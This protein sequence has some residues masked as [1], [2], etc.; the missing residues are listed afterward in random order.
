MVNYQD[1]NSKLWQASDGF[2]Q[3]GG[4]KDIPH[5]IRTT[6]VGQKWTV[7]CLSA[8]LRLREPRGRTLLPPQDCCWKRPPQCLQQGAS[9]H[10][11]QVC[12]TELGVAGEQQWHR[13]VHIIVHTWGT[14]W[15]VGWVPHLW[16]FYFLFY[17]S[18][19]FIYLY[20]IM[21]LIISVLLSYLFYYIHFIYLYIH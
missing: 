5:G 21:Y 18:I 2:T 3:W 11:W 4:G 15:E 9:M 6:K 7:S 8:A 12:V 17:S 19:W 14:S 13:G 20:S 16:H 10:H 1:I